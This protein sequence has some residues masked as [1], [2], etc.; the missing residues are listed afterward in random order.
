MIHQF[1]AVIS[2]YLDWTDQLITLAIPPSGMSMETAKGSYEQ[3]DNTFL[4][5][6]EGEMLEEI[7][8]LIEDADIPSGWNSE[9]YDIPYHPILTLECSARKTHVRFCLFN[10]SQEAHI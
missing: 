6:D 7:M 3:I 5:T 9:G 4:F 2:L 10:P 8:N 1:I